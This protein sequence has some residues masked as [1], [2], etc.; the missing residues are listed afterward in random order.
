MAREYTCSSCGASV[1]LFG[2]PE[3]ETRCAGC[4]WLMCIDDPTARAALRAHML[5]HDIIGNGGNTGPPV[6]VELWFVPDVEEKPAPADQSK[7]VCCICG[8]EMLTGRPDAE[9]RAEHDRLHRGHEP[10]R[11]SGRACGDCWLLVRESGLF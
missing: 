8:E 5:A 2:G 10:P 9:A 4:N 6:A 7:Y 11:Q 1:I 3:T